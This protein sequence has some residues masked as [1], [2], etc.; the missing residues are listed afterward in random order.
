[1]GDSNGHFPHLETTRFR[2][3]EMP[4]DR[5]LQSQKIAKRYIELRYKLMA[6]TYT[7]ALKGAITGEPK[8]DRCI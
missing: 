5:N 1:M 2:S 6:Y 3:I 8:Q 4:M 7:Y